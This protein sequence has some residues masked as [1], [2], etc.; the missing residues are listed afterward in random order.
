MG[1]ETNFKDTYHSLY[2]Y[3]IS[4]KIYYIFSCF[5][6]TLRHLFV[7]EQT[8]WGL[9]NFSSKE[10]DHKNVSI[11][12]LPFRAILTYGLVGLLW[13]ATKGGSKSIAYVN[14]CLFQELLSKK[15]FSTICNTSQKFMDDLELQNV[16]LVIFG[17]QTLTGSPTFLRLPYS[18]LNLSIIP[19][20]GPRQDV[21]NT[22]QHWRVVSR[23]STSG[24]RPLLQL[25][26]RI[27]SKTKRSRNKLFQKWYRH[28]LF[29]LFPITIFLINSYS[30]FPLFNWDW[31]A[32]N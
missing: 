27:K 31:T 15:I 14:L 21:C 22:G 24:L 18:H 6:V 8:S 30:K 17:A 20:A 23:P 28:L 4:K 26:W 5:F 19:D 13:G 16:M 10:N 32:M 3:Y 29:I 11:K 9:P 12:S 1:A 2:H 7:F 25:I